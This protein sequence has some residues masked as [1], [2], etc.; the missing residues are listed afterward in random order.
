MKNLWQQY[1]QGAGIV[2]F[3]LMLICVLAFTS[4]SRSESVCTGL[5]VQITDLEQYQFVSP[6]QI[7]QAINNM[8]QKVVG[9]KIRQLHLKEIEQMLLSNSFI[10]TAQVY[11]NMKGDMHA[12]IS[13]RVPL[14]RVYGPHKETYYIDQDGKSMP[15]SMNFAA[16]VP[17]ATASYTETRTDSNIIRLNAKLFR[18][19]QA[20]E[21][22]SFARALSGQITFQPN[23]EYIISPRLGNFE[24]ELGDTSALEQKFS[25]LKSFY[26]HA[27]PEEGYQRYGSISVKYRNQV[28]AHRITL[29]EESHG[30]ERN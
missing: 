23:G 25:A 13:Q 15:L 29:N 5:Y 16:N 27:L 14:M 20:I 7:G 9:R 1:M 10:K 6:A 11:I 3:A 30:R 28:V 2:A 8:E 18:L 17:V 26:R 4:I 12:I 21:A 22:D 24:I 19:A